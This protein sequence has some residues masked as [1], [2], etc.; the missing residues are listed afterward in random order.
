MTDPRLSQAELHQQLLDIRAIRG[1]LTPQ[2]VVDTA[3]EATHPLHSRFEWDN[4]VAGEAWR[5]TQAAELIRSVRVTYI[6]TADGEERRVRAWS[7]APVAT[8][9][10]YAPTE[11]IL[12]DPFASKLLLQQAERELKAFRQKYGH[13]QEFAAII[14]A[15]IA[16]NAA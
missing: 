5:R 6:E 1:E 15:A 16:E 9:T 10:G 2:G 11:E 12:Q 7:A 8:Q 4:K 14:A 3:R 13:L